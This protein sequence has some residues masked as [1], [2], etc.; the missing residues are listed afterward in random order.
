MR[1][2][3]ALLM[4]GIAGRVAAA[5]SDLTPLQCPTTI[6]PGMCE[7]PGF[8]RPSRLAVWQYYAVDRSGHFR[9]RTPLTTEPFN[10]ATVQPRIYLPYILD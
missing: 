6:V 4:V 2:T 5:D 9:P 1:L 8:E 7:Y 10:K 3:L